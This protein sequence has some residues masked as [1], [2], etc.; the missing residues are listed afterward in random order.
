MSD[1]IPVEGSEN[2]MVNTAFAVFVNEYDADK[3]FVSFGKSFYTGHPLSTES[4][5][6]YIRTQAD[7]GM[8]TQ[9]EKGTVS[10]NFE[11][12]VLQINY[13]ISRNEILA[14]IGIDNRIS[15]PKYQYLIKN[16]VNDLYFK[17]LM[18]R[19]VQDLFY[20]RMSNVEMETVIN[21]YS[22]KAY[23]TPTG[24]QVITAELINARF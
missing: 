6:R 18:W 3:A 1:F 4:N 7:P 14:A 16:V 15:L 12:Y 13:P 9:L 19:W 17:P 2:Y 23:I 21:N 10:T 20:C 22:S 5:T 24:A 11:A 8:F